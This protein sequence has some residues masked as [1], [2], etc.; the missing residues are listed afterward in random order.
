M[1]N[2]FCT[3]RTAKPVLTITNEFNDCVFST[4]NDSVAAVPGDGLAGIVT[5]GAAAPVVTRDCVL[6][7]STLLITMASLPPLERSTDVAVSVSLAANC[8]GALAM[9]GQT[10][11]FPFAGSVAVTIPTLPVPRKRVP[12][13]AWVGDAGGSDPLSAI[14]EAGSMLPLT[15]TSMPPL[16]AAAPKLSVPV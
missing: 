8:S 7:L 15:V 11:A 2:E 16:G 12:V 1:P 3:P 6:L 4:A 9:P 14:A 13:M 10:T 5:V